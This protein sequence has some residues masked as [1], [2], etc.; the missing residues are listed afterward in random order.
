MVHEGSSKQTQLAPRYRTGS[1]FTVASNQNTQPC[2]AEPI[3]CQVG[4]REPL[5]IRTQAEA[6]GCGRTYYKL[7]TTEHHLECDG[8]F[9]DSLSTFPST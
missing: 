2:V 4:M 7:P 3:S 8:Y 1:R 6:E 9:L 5:K